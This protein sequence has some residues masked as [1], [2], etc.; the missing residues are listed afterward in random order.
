M[1]KRIAIIFEDNIYCQRG[2]FNAIRNRIKH[3]RDIVDFEIDVFVINS[4]EPWYIRKMRH[5][6]KVEKVK[7]IQLDGIEYR[8][9][10]SRFTLT[11]Y[12]LDSKLHRTP[13]FSQ[14]YYRFL[15]NK[16]RGYDLISAHSTQCGLLASRI[17][18]RDGIP[19]CVTWHGTDIHTSPFISRDEYS[20]VHSILNAADCNFFVSQSL[21]NTGLS[22]SPK[23][24]CEVLY[25]GRNKHFEKYPEEL[26]EQLR[27][28]N[29]VEDGA[30]VVAFVGNLVGVKNPNLLAPI[31]LSVQRL[32]HSRVVFWVIGSGK[33][34]K[35]VEED[36]VKLGVQCKFWGG[37]PADRMPSFMNCIDVLVLPSRNEGLPLV[38][39]EAIACGANVAGSDV[40]GTREAIGKDNV[41]PHGDSF[42]QS[43]SERIA[44]MLSH[45]VD[46]PLSN[47]FEWENTAQKEF[48][49]YS[50]LLK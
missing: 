48:E 39:V 15:T 17:S 37:Q 4:Y 1:K 26:R 3:L 8:V 22:I 24:K 45:K 9:L 5:T 34:Q 46:Q 11:D 31:F 13:F 32:Y 47:V 28:R 36:M 23:M 33:M 41:F 19:F 20:V 38:V 35:E 44:Y 2:M 27:E 25:N 42:I 7:T 10:W 14:L 43:I 49:V 16:I 40:G 18:K 29:G 12:I 50:S 30:K 21:L 6:E